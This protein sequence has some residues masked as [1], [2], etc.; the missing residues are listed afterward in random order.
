MY[1]EGDN[2]KQFLTR[3]ATNRGREA[4]NLGTAVPK[5]CDTASAINKPT[6]SQTSSRE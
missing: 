5:N 6:T 1:E 2:C 3:G 4:I